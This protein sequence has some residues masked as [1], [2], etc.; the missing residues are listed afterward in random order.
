MSRTVVIPDLAVVLSVLQRR[1][2]AS[3]RTA[4]SEGSGGEGR[5]GGDDGSK[6]D[7]LDLPTG[8]GW[9]E[10]TKKEPRT[11][12]SGTDAA[13]QRD[14]CMHPMA[15]REAEST[16]NVPW[17][18]EGTRRA[19]IKR[20]C[21]GAAMDDTLDPSGGKSCVCVVS[22]P[23]VDTWYKRETWSVLTTGR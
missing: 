21:E 18:Q 23:W 15:K 4:G 16:T 13:P 11:T 6:C 8:A 1:E 19:A 12:L 5:D 20:N 9:T 10:S 22:S 17:L 2:E 7:E 14:F 3:R